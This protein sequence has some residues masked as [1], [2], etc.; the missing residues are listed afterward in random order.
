LSRVNGDSLECHSNLS[1]PSKALDLD[2]MPRILSH[3]TP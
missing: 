1:S 3:Y 2:E